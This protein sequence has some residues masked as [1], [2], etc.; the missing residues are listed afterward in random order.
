MSDPSPQAQ[1]DGFLTR[2]TPDIAAQTVEALRR[3]RAQVP[4]AVEMVYDNY[5]ALVIGFGATERASEAVLS[6]AVM[7]R[8]VDLCFIHDAASL[9][10][11][12]G[13]L[14]G[15]GKVARHVV[16]HDPAD[17]EKPAIRALIGH[18][19]AGSPRPFDTAAPG[20]MVI[21]SIS[22]KQRP[23]RPEDRPPGKHRG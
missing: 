3:L 4:G 6:I 22:A 7:P 8:W 19:V 20:R 9:P 15:S 16:L 23:R 1:L 13:L 11:P 10:D 18:A 21:K 12:E 2:Y 14:Q 17:L 5:N